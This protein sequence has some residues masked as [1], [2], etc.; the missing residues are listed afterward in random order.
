MKTK[1]LRNRAPILFFLLLLLS[2]A[3]VYL[4]S[5]SSTYQSVRAAGLEGS[6]SHLPLVV[7]DYFV[8]EPGGGLDETFGGT[9]YVVTPLAYNDLV[10][11]VVV[12]A[13]GKIVAVG[14]TGN[15]GWYDFAVL[16]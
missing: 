8:S 13:D 4:I 6:L 11:A 14:R 7:K 12:Q 16:R 3:A 10:N 9:G 5:Q 1:I 15:E 2:F